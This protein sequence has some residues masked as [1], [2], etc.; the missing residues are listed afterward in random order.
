MI[1]MF[2]WLFL[3]FGI[4]FL[5]LTVSSRIRADALHAGCSCYCPACDADLVMQ[6]DALIEDEDFVWY[7]CQ[8]C[9]TVSQWDFDYPVPVFIAGGVTVLRD[10]D[11]R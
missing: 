1:S 3:V 4:G 2:A 5:C 8:S 10:S 6:P 11:G 9:G 7:E